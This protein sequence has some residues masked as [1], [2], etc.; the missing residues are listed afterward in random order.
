MISQLASLMILMCQLREERQRIQAKQLEA[1]ARAQRADENGIEMRKMRM[2]ETH[3]TRIAEKHQYMDLPSLIFF[4]TFLV[5][6]FG[7]VLTICFALAFAGF[8][9]AIL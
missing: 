2:K 7:S 1:E 6:F 5:L 8:G 9:C 3:P 4:N